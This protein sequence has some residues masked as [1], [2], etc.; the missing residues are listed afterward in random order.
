M[1]ELKT[2]FVFQITLAFPFLP[3]NPTGYFLRSFD[4]TRQ[5]LFKWTVNWRFV[6]EE[7]F[8]SREFSMT[9]LIAHASL[10]V[11]F[12]TTRWT[13]PSGIPLHS[14][15][16][17]LFQP[18][19]PQAKQ[20]TSFLVTPSFVLTT[21]LTAMAVG[22]L[23]ARSLHYQFYSYVAWITPFLLWRSG[24]H[25]ILTYLVWAVQEWAW[26]VYPSTN[27]SSS[28]VVAC[29]AVQVFGVWWGSRN[30]FAEAFG[31]SK[32][33]EYGQRTDDAQKVVKPT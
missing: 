3:A 25:P 29:L 11:L 5:F 14:L 26:N 31:S 28:V 2:D 23:C 7:T 12:S 13:Q 22:L 8:L 27:T 21:T 15:A 33:S 6:G 4:I 19:P 1:T 9:L 32:A 24:M 18:L 30:D 16:R 20:Q 10:L 17:T